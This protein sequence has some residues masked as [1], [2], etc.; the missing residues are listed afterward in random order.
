MVRSNFKFEL[1]QFLYQLIN[2]R[3]EVNVIGIMEPQNGERKVAEMSRKE[4]RKAMK[5]MKRKQVRKDV[6]E[7]GRERGGG[8][9]VKRSGGAG[10]TEGD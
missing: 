5:K 2:R 10:E 6:A 4:K 9:Q 3:G 8:G 1:S 7:K